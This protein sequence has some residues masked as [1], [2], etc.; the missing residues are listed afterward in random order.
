MFA[1]WPDEFINPLWIDVQS[2]R[3]RSD[4]QEM[5]SP[6]VK[7][8]GGRI[9]PLSERFMWRKVLS[10]IHADQPRTSSVRSEANARRGAPA[11][12][13]SALILCRRHDSNAAGVVAACAAGAGANA[14]EER[15]TEHSKAPT[16][17]TRHVVLVAANNWLIWRFLELAEAR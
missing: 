1:R 6:H 16:T 12:A 2:E 9:G 3:L 7:V 8:E 13:R 11:A 17:N 15:T 10:L 4:D 5:F 14:T